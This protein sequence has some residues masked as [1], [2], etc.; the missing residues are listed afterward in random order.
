VQ[1]QEIP[2][3]S[4]TIA[5][6]RAEYGRRAVERQLRADQLAARFHTFFRTRNGA[7]CVIVGLA[8]LAEKERLLPLLLS[9]PIVLFVSA[10]LKKNAVYRAW[11]LA[12]RAVRFYERRLAN[13][14]ERWPGT[15]ESGSRFLD[16][17]HPCARDLDL[18]GS[19]SLYERLHL[20]GTPLG[21]GTLAAWLRTPAGAEEIRAR[22]AA[23]A[24][25]RDRLDL[26]EDLALLGQQMSARFDGAALTAWAAGQSTINLH[27]LRPATAACAAL[28]MLTL[29]VYLLGL[30]AV[31][32]LAALVLAGGVALVLRS[33]VQQLPAITLEGV[34]LRLLLSILAHLERQ[35]LASPLLCRLQGTEAALPP[36]TALVRLVEA[37]PLAP[38]AFLVLK[39]TRL[40]LALEAWRKRYGPALPGWLAALGELEALSALAAYAFETPADPFPEVQDEGAW[41]E[42]KG[43]GHP[44]LPRVQCICNDV[45]LN[46]K[47]RLL[48][49]SG[50][51]MSGKSTLLRT[52]GV[53]AVLALAGAPVRAARLRLAPVTLGATLRLQDSLLEGRSRFFA[54][55]TRIRQLLDLAQSQPPLLFLLDELFS[56]TNSDD[57]RQG[58]EAVVR[59]LLDRGAVGLLTTHDLALTHLADVLAPRAVNVHF[60]DQ[61]ADGEM[62]FDYRMRPGVLQNGNGLALMRAVGIEV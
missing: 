34:D 21:E 18:F 50:S 58:A 6:P 33:R 26:R 28:T 14:D 60:A 44:L 40:A 20:A 56:G 1:P 4:I 3:P 16:E 48:I 54:E 52:V 62:T 41:F 36:F 17:K 12:L 11:Q 5:D 47:Q 37:R 53:N 38:L 42:A 30:G 23:V 8:W 46:A 51:N 10:V 57:R 59:R 22:Q 29:I 55:V 13:L 24:E 19:G 61:F 43:L 49:V 31:P 45:S 15:G 35:Q 27:L 7:F 9:L 32:F 2:P 39:S 25:L